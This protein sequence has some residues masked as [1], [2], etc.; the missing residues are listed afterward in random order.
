MI[1][2]IILTAAAV[3]LNLIYFNS[4][5]DKV[6]IPVVWTIIFSVIV[7]VLIC[8]KMDLINCIK[9]FAVFTFLNICSINDVIRHESDNIFPVLIIITGLMKPLNIIYMLFSFVIIAVMFAI[10][11]ISS[12][13]T[14]GG[15]DIKMI[16]ALAFFFG[17]EMTVTAVI[18]SCIT[19]IVYAVIIKFAKRLPDFNKHLAFLPFVEVGYLASLVMFLY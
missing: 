7:Y 5:H 12:K 1:I 6:I 17:L 18:I 4:K 13:H 3:F 9:Y 2:P 15:G 8:N 11:I 19:G 16:C 14:I 10:I